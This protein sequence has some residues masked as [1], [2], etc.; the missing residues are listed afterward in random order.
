MLTSGRLKR[1]LHV[2]QNRVVEVLMSSCSANDLMAGKIIGLS[3]LGITQMLFWVIIGV[4]VA[5]KFSIPMLPVPAL[6]LILAYIVLGYLLYA[7][8]FVAVGSPVSTEQ[9]AQQFTSYL[10]MILII[11][12]VLAFSVA[13]NPNS[14]LIK[15]LS[16]IPLLSPS[17]MIMRIPNQMPA[18]WEIVLTLVLVAV[19]VA[20]M[21]WV[22]GKIFR[23]TILSYGKRPSFGELIRLIRAS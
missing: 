23:T 17:F 19:S 10:V 18:L 14:T 2:A 1:Y 4:A 3:G 15:I 13:E 12:I 16:F 5:V 9:E 20:V 7:A 21:M 22:A 6:L 8:I 11:P